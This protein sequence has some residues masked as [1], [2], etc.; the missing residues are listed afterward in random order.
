MKDEKC[1][2]DKTII[3][4]VK[5]LHEVDF[6][7]ENNGILVYIDKKELNEKLDYDLDIIIKNY[8]D[9]TVENK[10]TKDKFYKNINNFVLNII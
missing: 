10:D 1:N 9:Y 8:I 6:I 7:R 4:D 5:F 3:S 2:L